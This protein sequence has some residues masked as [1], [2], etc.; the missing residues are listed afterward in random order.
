MPEQLTKSET[1]L[2]IAEIVGLE[3]TRVNADF[4]Q[5]TL[6]MLESLTGKDPS[7]DEKVEGLRRVLASLTTDEFGTELKNIIVEV[8]NELSED[9]VSRYLA[10][11]QY[12]LEVGKIQEQLYLRIQ[13]VTTRIS[14]GGTL[15]KP[16]H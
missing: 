3:A 13:E 15:Q 14:Q 10:Q 2:K 8:F 6:G 7:L 9:H 4:T 11:L 5:K 1:L 16:T 12:D